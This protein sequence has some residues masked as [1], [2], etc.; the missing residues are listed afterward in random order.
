MQSY[1]FDIHG[2]NRGSK[3]KK[4]SHI[5]SVINTFT[6][7]CDDLFCRSKKLLNFALFWNCSLVIYTHPT[8]MR[9]EEL[10]NSRL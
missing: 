9:R 1:S 3:D 2:S 4:H 10:D 7:K 5:Q 6:F 8:E